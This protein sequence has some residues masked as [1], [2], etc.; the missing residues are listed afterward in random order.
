MYQVLY[1]TFYCPFSF[2]ILENHLWVWYCDIEHESTN[3]RTV[4]DNIVPSLTRAGHAFHAFN[5][6][7]V[8]NNAE[9]LEGKDQT[10]E[11]ERAPYC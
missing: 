11:P 7:M 2:A 8:K 5:V 3:I 4:E 10:R 9:H 6:E 1:E